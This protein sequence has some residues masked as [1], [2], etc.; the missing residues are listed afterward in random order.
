MECPDDDLEIRALQRSGEPGDSIAIQGERRGIFGPPL[1]VVRLG[2][3]ETIRRTFCRK[4]TYGNHRQRR[5]D[6][7]SDHEDNPLMHGV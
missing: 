6:Q 7:E 3:V 4:G 1:R 2:I 5:T